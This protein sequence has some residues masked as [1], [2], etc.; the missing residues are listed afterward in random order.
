MNLFKSAYICKC[1]ICGFST[2]HDLLFANHV[3]K[4]IHHSKFLKNTMAPVNPWS[5]GMAC[6]IVVFVTLL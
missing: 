6:S 3:K 1:P 5:V 4:I 2:Y